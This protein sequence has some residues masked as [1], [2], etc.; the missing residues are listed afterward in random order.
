MRSGASDGNERNASVKIKFGIEQYHPFSGI[1]L[2][3]GSWTSTLYRLIPNNKKQAVAIADLLLYFTWT[4]A[5]VI[6]TTDIYG[7]GH[8]CIKKCHFIYILYS[9]QSFILY[10]DILCLWE[11]MIFPH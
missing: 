4:Q 6:Y 10:T 11:K 5:A 3:K 8:C 2:E 9:W 7:T 1:L